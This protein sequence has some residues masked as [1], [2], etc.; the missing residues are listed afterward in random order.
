MTRAIRRQV[1]GDAEHKCCEAQEQI[2]HVRKILHVVN[3][4]AQFVMVGTIPI[5]LWIVI[6]SLLSH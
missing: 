2:A 1:H 4:I 6:W 3:C 5:V